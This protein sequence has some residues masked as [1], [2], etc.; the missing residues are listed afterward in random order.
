MEK[1]DQ[2]SLEA[3]FEIARSKEAAKKCASVIVGS[4]PYVQA[5]S[6]TPKSKYKTQKQAGARQK[7]PHKTV[8]TP[9]TLPS[10]P[11][12]KTQSQSPKGTVCQKM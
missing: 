5:V 7:T 12:N 1:H 11:Q 6:S 9:P 10:L 8:A 3:A 2:L 4:D